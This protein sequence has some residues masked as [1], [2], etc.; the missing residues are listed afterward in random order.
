MSDLK[1]HKN[2]VPG[3]PVII[4]AYPNPSNYEI[5]LWGIFKVLWKSRGII[6]MSTI[7]CALTAT[8]IAFFIPKIYRAETVLLPPGINDIISLNIKTIST[9]NDLNTEDNSIVYKTDPAKVHREF[10]KNLQSS[11]IRYLFFKKFHLKDSFP[12]SA[13]MKAD[14]Y[15]LFKQEFD[16][17]IRIIGGENGK[18]KQADFTTV[19]LD[20]SD[21]LTL[22]LW[23]D[24]YI[25]FV[26]NY[27]VRNLVNDVQ[28]TLKGRTGNIQKNILTLK[29]IAIQEQ[30]D[31]VVRLKEA[32]AIAKH[33][34]IERP[35]GNIFAAK[36]IKDEKSNLKINTTIN[37]QTFPLYFRGYSV[38]QQELTQLQNRKNT[39]S[40][41]LGLR[42]LQGELTVLENTVVDPDL[43]HS[44]RIDQKARVSNKLV[45]P[46]RKLIIAIGVLLGL[47]VGFCGAFIRNIIAINCNKQ[48]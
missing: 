2:I 36:N 17:N 22:E 1:T 45:R 35:I 14:D 23:L 47:T 11:G 34:R 26:D 18:L 3:Q 30:A 25:K 13:K 28:A 6:I 24:N 9:H 41:I 29:K 42:E 40:F 37:G 5:D 16:Q 32:L 19:T 27:T 33:L 10:L 15:E 46:Q 43:I 38:I 7:T 44:F 21:N 48:S 4:Q 12:K 31:K 8:M 39:N 20:G